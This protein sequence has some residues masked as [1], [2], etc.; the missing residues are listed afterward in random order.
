MLEPSYLYGTIHIS[1]EQAFRFPEGTLQAFD[2]TKSFAMEIRA[3]GLS[4]PTLVQRITMNKGNT[5]S[6]LL[7]PAD[8]ALL[9]SLVL[10]STGFSVKL[11]NNIQPFFVSALLEMKHF[12]SDSSAPLD[13]WFAERAEKQ[14]KSIK[15]L[16]TVEEQLDAIGVLSYREQAD[17]LALEMHKDA[18]TT[19]LARMVQFYQN[20]QL[21][22]LLNNEFTGDMP[23]RLRK[24]LIEDRNQR[25]ANRLHALLS[26][27]KETVFAAVGA[28]HL[29]G[30]MGLIALLRKKGYFLEPVSATPKGKN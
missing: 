4:D 15:G 7:S 10:A 3:D 26:S 24:A 29:P 23:P 19:L 30:K 20:G 11:F 22:S 1:S 9:D 8:F 21:D 6:D 28:L 13:L 12:S 18:D 2:G 14:N 5:L 17:Y 16:E 27:K 25:M